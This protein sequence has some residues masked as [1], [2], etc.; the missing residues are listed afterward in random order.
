VTKGNLLFVAASAQFGN[1]TTSLSD[2]QGNL[3]HALSPVQGPAVN[4]VMYLFWAIAN[5]SGA[6]TVSFS[7]D[8]VGSF[9]SMATLE[10]GG[11]IPPFL[12][13]NGA[14]NTGINLATVT[15]NVIPVT[16]PPSLLIAAFSHDD[17]SRNFASSNPFIL[18]TSQPNGFT[19]EPLYVSDSID[20]MGST[21]ASGTFLNTITGL[22]AAVS[23]WRTQGASFLLNL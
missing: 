10:Y 4:A 16:T 15:T 18:R 1:N 6:C 3:W 21:S 13:S 2:T 11:V 9:Y 19:G 12:D 20:A 8:H 23:Q 17:A 5:A 14:S 22:P 7:F